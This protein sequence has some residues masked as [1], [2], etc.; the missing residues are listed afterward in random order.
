MTIDSKALQAK[1]LDA[2]GVAPLHTYPPDSPRRYDAAAV[3]AGATKLLWGE[4]LLRVG[5]VLTNNFT[6]S[7]FAD[8]V[9]VLRLAAD[10][11]DH[12]RPIRC[13][14]HVMSSSEDPIRS[15]CGLLVCPTARL[16]D[17]LDLDYVV[18]VGG[19]LHQHSPL[20]KKTQDYL[21]RAGQTKVKLAGICT[22]S[23]I[24]CRLGLL[25]GKKCC[26]HWFHYGDFL[27]EFPTLVPVADQI[28][29]IDGNRITS[30]GGTSVVFLAAEIIRRHLG[31]STAQKVL[32]IQQIDRF[33][34]GSSAQPAPPFGVCGDSARVSRALLFM[35]QNLA[36]PVRVSK[37]AARLNTSTRQLERLFKER[38]GCAP[39]TAYLRLRLKHARWMLR[40]DL[41]LAS[42]A[43][44]TGFSDGAHFGK[45]FKAA[46]GINPSEER[47]QLASKV[48]PLAAAGSGA[49]NLMRVFDPSDLSTP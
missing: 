37:I 5:F 8:F 42:V 13:Q 7:T 43:A 4:K 32:H 44:N 49:G 16:I 23:F 29:V 28:Y 31:F 46:Y 19:L 45:T 14:W 34:P 17:P 3:S 47:R 10:D 6:L 38:V 21:A 22:G 2:R 18:V 30:A 35:E 25:E 1:R 24:L 12:S 41:S 15:S 26:I 9:D 48:G 27:D 36:R 40:S 20:D 11:G 33:K 39:Q